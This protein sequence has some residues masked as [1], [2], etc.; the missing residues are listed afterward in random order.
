MFI[1]I[2]FIII[3]SWKKFYFFILY[4]KI[5]C[6]YCRWYIKR[7]Y[8]MMVYEKINI[9]IKFIYINYNKKYKY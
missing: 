8:E 7:L 5:G 1:L 6:V 4:N 9:K 3:K 2:F